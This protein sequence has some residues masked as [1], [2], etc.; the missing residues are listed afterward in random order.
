[1]VGT[2]ITGA[3]HDGWSKPNLGILHLTGSTFII[4][5]LVEGPKH[6]KDLVLI[7]EAALGSED[8]CWC[9]VQV[10]R[11]IS[12]AHSVKTERRLISSGLKAVA[13]VAPVWRPYCQ[14][15]SF[16]ILLGSQ[17]S[18]LKPKKVLFAHKA[19]PT[20]V[21]SC[22]PSKSVSSPGKGLS[23]SVSLC[24]AEYTGLSFIHYLVSR[25]NSNTLLSVCISKFW[26][27]LFPNYHWLKLIKM[28]YITVFMCVPPQLFLLVSMIIGL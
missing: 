22:L 5:D 6:E 21:G 2:W 14:Y 23:T 24:S 13:L 26:H 17:T 8:A 9:P 11:G 15:L 3:P 19:G 18:R 1:M 20:C 16:S 10:G 25:A 27:C 7:S 4:T 12:A 28:R